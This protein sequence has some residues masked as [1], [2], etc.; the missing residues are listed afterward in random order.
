MSGQLKGYLRHATGMC[1]SQRASRDRCVMRTQWSCLHYCAK[2]AGL[3]GFSGEA[4]SRCLSV[5]LGCSSHTDKETCS[6][7]SQLSVSLTKHWVCGK[8]G[9]S[10]QTLSVNGKT[11]HLYWTLSVCVC[12]CV[13]VCG[14]TGHSHQTLSVCG[15][16]GHSHWTLIICVVRQYTHI[17]H[18]VCVC[19]KTGHS[20][21]T[22]SVCGKKGHSHW[23]LIV[24]VVR[25]DT[26]IEHWLCV[27]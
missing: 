24:C 13:C 1:I 17:E 9:H 20:H 19:G 3:R 15:K 10:H 2:M 7:W 4:G 16:K 11:G 14:K 18:L 23:T 25:Q 12:V 5:Y 22:L 26:Y 27:W 21:W 8:T 6:W